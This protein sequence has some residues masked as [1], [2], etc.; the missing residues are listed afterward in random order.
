MDKLRFFSLGSGSSGNCYYIGNAKR[1]ILIDAGI[2]A[3]S[4]KKRLKS[5]GVS[6][7]QI[8]AVF[9]THDHFDHIKAVSALGNKEHI[10]VYSTQKIL[11]GINNNIKLR[12]KLEISAQKT[13]E[14][15]QSVQIGDFTIT[16]FPLSHDASDNSGYKIDYQGLTFTVA[17]DLGCPNEYLHEYIAQSDILILEANYDEIMLQTGP[18]PEKLKQRVAGDCGH[19]GNQQTADILMK[20]STDKLKYLFLCHLSQQNNKPELALDAV[21]GT[22]PKHTLINV[23]PR[24]DI[25]EFFEF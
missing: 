13:I 21:K 12:E 15:F 1:G 14:N 10:P 6:M 4:I 7:E 18:Y 24:T 20:S 19:L 16:S 25:S 23:L 11:D 17:T 8:L 3:R 22:V 2:G 9:V 5:A